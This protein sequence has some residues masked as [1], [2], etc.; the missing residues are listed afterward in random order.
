MVTIQR[1]KQQSHSSFILHV[2]RKQ[3]ISRTDAGEIVYSEMG[4]AIRGICDTHSIQLRRLDLASAAA[5][6]RTTPQCKEAG[7]IDHQAMERERGQPL[8][9]WQGPDSGSTHQGT[10]KHISGSAKSAGSIHRVI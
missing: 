3:N 7:A 1:S 4:F 9:S 5:F 10:D 2:L 6:P 8:D